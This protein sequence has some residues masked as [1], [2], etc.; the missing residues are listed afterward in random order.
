MG[1]MA[2]I[3]AVDD[4]LSMRNLVKSV[5]EKRGHTVITQENGKSA[6]DYAESNSVDLVISDIN[7]PEC[8]GI[9]GTVAIFKR[10]SLYSLPFNSYFVLL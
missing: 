8:N 9:E 2:T 3:M 7:M 1:N 4:M 6:L 5:L 10:F